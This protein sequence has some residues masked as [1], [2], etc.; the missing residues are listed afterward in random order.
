MPEMDGV[1]AIFA[2]KDLIDKKLISLKYNP[3]IIVLSAHN[4]EIIISRV[5]GNPLVKE[6]VAKPLRKSKLEEI[7]KKYYF[8]NSEI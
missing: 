7:L 6:F 3:T 8:E 4:S 5:L 2:I 1:Q